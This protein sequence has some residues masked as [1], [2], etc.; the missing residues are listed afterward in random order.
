ME[1]QEWLERVAYKKCL[2]VDDPMNCSF[3]DDRK[4]Y[5]VWL[6]K[7]DNSYVTLVGM[8]GDVKF[9]ADREITEEL[10]HGLGFSPKD[11]K[12]YG[13]SHRAIY[14]FGIGSTCKMGDCHYVPS[15]KDDFLNDTIAFWSGEN[16]INVKGEH[17]KD[18]GVYG[19]YVC[20][21]YDDKTPNE[22]IRGKIT[23]V[24]TPYPDEFGRGEWVAES[25]DD[26]KK[27]AIDFCSGVS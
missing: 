17:S 16:K 10:T 5:E 15:D 13:W 2:T 27:M 23:G 11:G 22:N 21:E 7:F 25:I 3:D 4:E 8:E 9:L 18:G 14:G 1:V 12:W 6:S 24:F 26:A 20:W 19:V